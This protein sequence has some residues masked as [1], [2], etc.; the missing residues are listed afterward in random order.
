MKNTIILA[1]LCISSTAFSQVIIGDGV[2]TASN[3]NSVLLEFSKTENKGMILPYVR[4]LPSNPTEGTI[5]V[6]ASAP[7]TSA[8]KFYNGAWV[9]LSNGNTGDISKELANQPNRSEDNTATTIIGA[10]NSTAEG[11]LVLESTN[12]AMVLPTVAS[13]DDIVNPSPGMM[14]YLSKDKLFAVYNGNQWSFWE[15]ID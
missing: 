11:V 1:A 15:A 12:K 13:T 14:V 8:V 10:A 2:G 4:T 9:D 7:A 6:D 3:K 5:L